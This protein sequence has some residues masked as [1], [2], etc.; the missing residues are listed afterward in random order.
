MLP[1]K[2]GEGVFG[3]NSGGVKPAGASAV[4]AAGAGGAGAGAACPSAAAALMKWRVAGLAENE[5][6]EDDLKEDDRR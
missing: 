2:I 5:S 3:S 4:S 6:V 1:A